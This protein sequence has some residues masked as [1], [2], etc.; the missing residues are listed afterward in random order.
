MD[1]TPTKRQRINRIVVDDDENDDENLSN[2]DL[3]RDNISVP[4]SE[5]EGEDLLENLYDDYLPIA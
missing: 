2:P 4:S 3:Q 5:E 1:D